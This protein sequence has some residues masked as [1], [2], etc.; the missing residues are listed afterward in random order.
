MTFTLHITTDSKR[1]DIKDRCCEVLAEILKKEGYF[2]RRIQ[3]E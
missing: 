3:P 1:N 2:L